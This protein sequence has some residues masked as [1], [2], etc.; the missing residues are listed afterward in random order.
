MIDTNPSLSRYD[1]VLINRLRIGHTTLTNC[2]L[3][4][5]ENQSECQICYSPVTAKHI[6]ID[7][8][9]FGAAR[10]K[11]LGVDTLKEL[12]ENVK[13]RNIIAFLKDTYF[14]CCI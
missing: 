2:Y 10:Q 13:S 1:R 9:C 3:L 14:D 11:Y 5:A 4:K 12:L 6:F 7:S 8:T